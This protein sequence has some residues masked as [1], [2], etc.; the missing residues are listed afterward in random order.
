VS[1]A[2]RA[3]AWIATGPVG[4][5]AAFLGDLVAFASRRLRD[6]VRERRAR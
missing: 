6:R 1:T 2:D 3:L 5:V 4:R